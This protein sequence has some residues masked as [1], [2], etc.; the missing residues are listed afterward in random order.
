MV[1]A[2]LALALLAA[3]VSD[4]GEENDA[5]VDDAGVAADARVPTHYDT[6]P[7]PLDGRVIDFFPDGGMPRRE[8]SWL[9]IRGNKVMPEEVYVNALHLAEGTVPDL[10]TATYIEETL[11]GELVDL[12]LAWLDERGPFEIEGRMYERLRAAA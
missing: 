6:G 10:A 11:Y 1:A 9:K 12:T 5:A 8:P 3:S 7:L 4:G 2:S